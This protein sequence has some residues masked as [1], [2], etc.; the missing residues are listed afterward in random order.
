VANEEEEQHDEQTDGL[1][2]AWASFVLD[3]VE[4]L[5]LIQILF[6]D[7][8]QFGVAFE[9]GV[10]EIYFV[11][12]LFMSIGQLIGI[13]L[14]TRGR[15]RLGGYFQIASSAGQVLKLDGVFGVVGGLKALRFAEAN[16][17]QLRS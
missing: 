11:M 9:W 17:L 1:N 3:V 14:V 6:F 4:S 7:K 13:A 5:V 2:W 10:L 8:Q 15:Y 16:E 12:T